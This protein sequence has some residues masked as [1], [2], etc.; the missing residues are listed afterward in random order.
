MLTPITIGPDQLAIR[1]ELDK[2]ESSRNVHLSYKRFSVF[3]ELIFSSPCVSRIRRLDL[4]HNNIS[5]L[6]TSIYLLTD[7]RELWLQ[8]NP[9]EE[10]GRQIGSFPEDHQETNYAAAAAADFLV[11]L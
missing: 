1:R 10:T 4:G 6:P 9:I 8:H 7:L 5:V 2:A 3:P 11:R